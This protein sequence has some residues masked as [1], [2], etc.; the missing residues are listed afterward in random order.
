MGDPSVRRRRLKKRGLE[1]LLRQTR[2]LRE[3]LAVYKRTAQ[4]IQG[5]L[6]QILPDSEVELMVTPRADLLGTLECLLNDDL[7]AAVRHLGEVEELLAGPVVPR[8]VSTAQPLGGD[9]L[10]VGG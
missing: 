3:Q 1:N 2:Q 7:E 4:D 5:S 6:D 10:D 9:G 8:R